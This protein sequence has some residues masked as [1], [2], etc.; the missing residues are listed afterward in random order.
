MIVVSILGAL[1]WIGTPDMEFVS[2]GN[3]V[4]VG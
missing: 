1:V 4:A 3:R 2:L